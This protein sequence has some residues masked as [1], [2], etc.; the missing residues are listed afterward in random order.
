MTWRSGLLLLILL[1]FPALSS[2]SV[3]RQTA[4]PEVLKRQRLRFY[5]VSMV[6]QW[7]LAGACLLVVWS[8]EESLAE[9]GLRVFEQWSATVK[10]G[11]IVTGVLVAV[12]AL[13]LWLQH[14]RRWRESRVLMA[15]LPE[16]R[17]EKMVFVALAATAGFCEE[18]LYRGFAIM[19]LALLT[20]GIWS[21]AV[22]AVIVFSAGHFYQGAIG[23]WR[24]ATLGAVL[25]GTFIITGSVVPGM[26]AHFLI[27]A[28]AGFWGRA[29][30]AKAATEPQSH[31]V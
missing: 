14:K 10:V 2:W 5:L 20:G 30:L 7:V 8:D 21:A 3:R 31:R 17:K 18:I 19:R 15:I 1:L 12:V 25:A 28:L 24:A 22:M 9:I 26:I 11:L 27:D 29:W 16:T 13:I 6:A 4:V 23:V